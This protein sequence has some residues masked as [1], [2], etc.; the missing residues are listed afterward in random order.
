MK[1]SFSNIDVPAWL[2]DH[3]TKV[4]LAAS[5]AVLVTS[6]V[7][8]GTT[9][10]APGEAETSARVEARVSQLETDLATS[11]SQLRTKHE[12]LLNQLSG[13][14]VQR[15]TR[16]TDVA[17]SLALVIAG[18]SSSSD[19]AARQEKSLAA[20]YPFLAADG[21]RALSEFLPGWLA[22]TAG[23]SYTLVEVQPRVRGVSGLTYDYFTLARLDPVEGNGSPQIL[24]MTYRTEEDGTVSNFEVSRA[25]TR[26]RDAYL[27]DAK[28]SSRPA[29][30]P[31]SSPAPSPSG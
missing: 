27:A 22:D 30:D 7:T 24:V 28:N 4:A 2:S 5:A 11:R 3:G 26:T 16:D 17:R 25:S 31:S 20:R 14:N 12:E 13:M 9:V 10:S 21:S 8:L 18:T 1:R 29:S 23:T 15:T 6:M 19:S